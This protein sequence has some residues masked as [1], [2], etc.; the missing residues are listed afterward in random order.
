[1]RGHIEKRGKTWSAVIDMPRDPATGKRRQ[2]R[3]T[4]PTKR[5][6]EA[7]MAEFIA[8]VEQGG[9]ADSG[10]LTVSEYLEQWLRTV[11]S[12]VRPSTY[13]RYSDLMRKRVVPAVGSVRLGKLTPLHAQRLYTHLLE[14]GLSATTVHLVH[15]ILHRSLKQAVRWGLLTRNVTESVDAPQPMNPA[16]KT[17][18]ADQVAAVLHAAEKDALAALWRL[19]LLCGLR[20][21]ELFGLQWRDG[22]LE[23][24]RCHVARAAHWSWGRQRLRTGAA[25]LRY[26]LP[27]WRVCGG[28]ASISLSTD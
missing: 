12:N 20:R 17:W 3:I 15:N 5:A 6:A 28:I 4:A 2:K 24:G 10:Q 22:N 9:F 11:E 19:A 14:T 27:A 8:S 25:R 13:R 1:M 18:S 21:G 7:K 26:P 16:G 23:W